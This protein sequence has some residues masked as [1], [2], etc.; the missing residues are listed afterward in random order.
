MSHLL[1]ERV[2]R[3]LWISTCF[4][5]I[6]I[7]SPKMKNLKTLYLLILTLGFCLGVGFLFKKGIINC[8]FICHM[9]FVCMMMNLLNTFLWIL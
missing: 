6:I 4:L 5:G 2:K 3:N 1:I 9:S 7:G 8:R